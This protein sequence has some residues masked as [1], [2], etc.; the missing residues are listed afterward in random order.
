MPVEGFRM[1]KLTCRFA[2]VA[3][4]ILL[5]ACAGGGGSPPA[6][7][8]QLPVA[9]VDVPAGLPGLPEGGRFHPGR[10]V[11]AV[12]VEL[13]G[14]EASDHSGN[15]S[16]DGVRAQLAPAA[17][18]LAWAIYEFAG[19]PAD[20][21]TAIDY[22]AVEREPGHLVYVAISNY[23]ENAWEYFG[24]RNQDH[25]QHV[26]AG[27]AGVYSSP[28]GYC[29]IAVLAFD[30]GSFDLDRVNVTYAN[31]YPVS[32]QVVDP[33]G[34]GV[35]DVTITTTLGGQSTVTGA[36]GT[37]S[38][39][40]LPDGGW[41]LMA[42]RT[43]WVFFD[44]P[45]VVTVSGG[46]FSGVLIV[47]EHNQSHY[48][49][50]DVLEPN[51]TAWQASE[52]D[53][54]QT[55]TAY[56]SASDDRSDTYRFTLDTPGEYYARFAG[57][58]T[59]LF[60]DVYIQSAEGSS[61]AQS[62]WMYRGVVYV[63]F[64][65]AEARAVTVRIIC[66][67]GGGQ[68]TL[69]LGSG[70]LS[71]LW[72]EITSAADSLDYVE[73]KVE[74]GD[75]TSYLYSTKYSGEYGSDYLMPV[76]TEITPDPHDVDPYSYTPL[77]QALDLSLGDAAGVD[78][79][80]THGM[81]AD[82]YEPNDSDTEAA[83]L[84]LPLTA[85]DFMLIGAADNT[86]YYYVTPTAGK[87]MIVRLSADHGVIEDYEPIRLA[88]Y[89]STKSVYMNGYR[90][91]HGWEARSYGP[92]DG[93]LYYVVVTS[94]AGQEFPYELTIQE[95]D[96]YR[97]DIGGRWN[98]DGIMNARV[99]LYDFE[100]GWT[101]GFVT[102]ADGCTD[103]PFN[104]MDGETLYAEYFRYG[105]TCDRYTETVTIDGA[106]QTVWFSTIVAESADK[107]EPNDDAGIAVDF[108]LS[109]D[110]TI[111][112]LT[113]P[114]DKYILT[115]ATADP[116]HVVF[117]TPEEGTYFSATLEDADTM[118]QQ[119][120]Y[121]WYGDADFLL[122]SA[123]PVAQVLTISGGTEGDAYHIEVDETEGYSISGTIL[124]DSSDVVWHTYIYSPDI[125]DD[126]HVWTGEYE[127]GPF[128]PGSY[129]IYVYSTNYYVEPHSPFTAVFTDADLVQ[130]FVL[131]EDSSDSY[132]PNDS[133]G[134]A[135]TISSGSPLE[136]NVGGPFDSS[137][138]YR[139]T[140]GPGLVSLSVEFQ[141]WAAAV[142]MELYDHD[143]TTKLAGSCLAGG[144]CQR[145]DYVLPAAT[146]Y[147]I[148]LYGGGNE[149]TVS[150][151]F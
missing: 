6:D 78:F 128:P 23:E 8:L 39:D 120:A 51:M 149:Y 4:S 34:A 54:S 72:G 2:V 111:S 85:H 17:G 31:R 144:S 91:D 11:A 93:E 26:P 123:G 61:F 150:A 46:E 80:G 118:T 74:A 76:A 66:G 38:L 9:V 151:N 130:D 20:E 71:S 131:T 62:D 133:P 41:H 143:G 16:F 114:L 70:S 43:G 88:L 10:I 145:I 48:E 99:D 110:A 108:P 25:G 7:S 32:G 127:L 148:R 112:S 122:K 47:G 35:P 134:E 59:I 105:L 52:C 58:D 1:V 92:C 96:G 87:S 40:G 64:T 24:A 126:M 101:Q 60:P 67:G 68:Y 103:I 37:F 121:Y 95:Y 36:D 55:I 30:G 18:E 49:P 106:D 113:D 45:T 117:D 65:I 147:Y 115:P 139:F 97:L 14:N 82:D 21:I 75:E 12:S 90:T 102:L 89:D 119:D 100:Y 146:S 142:L 132:E 42:T 29:H 124:D 63:G 141:H 56:I 3:A 138:W 5:A 94:S 109:T 129:E 84:P 81:V 33:D 83:E 27:G 69:D 98:E 137:D 125:E 13:D 53:P 28:T 19:S 57:S 104:F 44:N 50:V 79:F 77:Y 140:G 86:D 116:M 107:W 22:W 135:F 73:V 15:V 136:A